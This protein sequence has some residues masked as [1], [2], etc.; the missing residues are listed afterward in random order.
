MTAEIIDLAKYKR[1]QRITVF[2]IGMIID[3]SFA[4]APLLRGKNEGQIHMFN[5]GGTLTH[6][7]VVE[8]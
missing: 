3:H 8:E 5:D 7:V 2:G 4:I 6:T 1:E